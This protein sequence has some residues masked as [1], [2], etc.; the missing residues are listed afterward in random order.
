MARKTPEEIKLRVLEKMEA[1]RALAESLALRTSANVMDENDPGWARSARIGSTVRLID[2]FEL[3]FPRLSK[4]AWVLGSC[5][6]ITVSVLVLGDHLKWF[7][8]E[9]VV[10]GFVTA[11]L[12]PLFGG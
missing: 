8:A 12:G 1:R 3:Y 5:G 10:A 6:A 11:V 2:A 9:E 4:V 7:K